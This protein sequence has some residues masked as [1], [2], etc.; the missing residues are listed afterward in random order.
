MEN[1]LQPLSIHKI[2]SNFIHTYKQI[3]TITS[4]SST[5][6]MYANNLKEKQ[7]NIILW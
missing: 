3:H 2:Y 4:F 6:K 7:R 5:V 1:V